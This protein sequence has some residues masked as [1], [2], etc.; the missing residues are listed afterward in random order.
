[1]ELIKEF[2]QTK[3]AK[4]FLWTMLNVIMGFI[5][6]LLTF[7]A[8]NS[9]EWASVVLIVMTPLSQLLTKYLNT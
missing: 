9:V 5:L 4:R 7:L 1:M 2:L 8:S 3:E 6:A